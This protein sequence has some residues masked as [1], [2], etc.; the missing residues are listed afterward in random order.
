MFDWELPDVI[1]EQIYGSCAARSINNCKFIQKKFQSVDD[2]D[3]LRE[4]IEDLYVGE[5]S[6]F[7]KDKNRN[8]FL[9][10]GLFNI[11]IEPLKNANFHG[12]NNKEHVVDFGLFLSDKILIAGYCDGGD[13]FARPEIKYSYENR[14]EVNEKNIVSNTEIG[15]GVGTGLVYRFADL[16]AVDNSSKTLYLGILT[17]NSYFFKNE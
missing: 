5:I 4:M 9:L 17:K 12:G 10:P 8:M 11:L 16:L 2:V 3:F 6:S 15:Y 13:F 1:D 7:Y 14:I